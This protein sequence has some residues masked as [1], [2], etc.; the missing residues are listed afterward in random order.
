MKNEQKLQADVVVVGTGGSGMA[1]ATS[2]LEAGANKIIVLEKS[3][4]LGGNTWLAGGLCAVDSP[5]Q[6]RLGITGTSDKLFKQ[7]MEYSHWRNDP[8]I[9][10]T[11]LDKSSE[12]IQWLEDKGL[13]FKYVGAAYADSV[14]VGH[15]LDLGEKGKCGRPIIKT[16]AKQLRSHGVKILLESKAEKILL[17]NKGNVRGVL[18]NIKGKETEV[19]TK[20]LILATGGFGWNKK[21]LKKYFPGYNDSVFS[22]GLPQMTGDGLLMAQ[23]AGAQLNEDIVFVL[24]GPHHYPYSRRITLLQRR[25]EV[26]W[27]NKLGERF[28]DESTFFNVAA[29]ASLALSQ[30]PGAISYTIIDSKNLQRILD[31]KEPLTGFEAV[32]GDNGA[33]LTELKSN[34][35]SEAKGWATVSQL[36]AD[37][38]NGCGICEDACSWHVIK[39]NT[40]PEGQSEVSPCR[41][42]C[43]AGVNMR[44]YIHLLRYGKMEEAYAVLRESLP[45]P[46]VTG[47]VCPHFCES[48]CARKDVDEAVNINSLERFVADYWSQEKAKPVAKKYTSK[49]AVVGSGP[50]GL[51]CAYFLAMAGYPV[52]VFESQSTLGGMLRTGIPEYRLP[53]KILDE[54]INYIRDIGVEFKTGV[55]IGKE[56]S[57]KK[58]QQEYQAVFL[59]TGN[60]LSRKIELEGSGLNGVQ[61]GLD[62]LQVVNLNKASNVKGKVVVIGGGNVA[63]D[64]ALT[65]IR[66]GAKDVQLACL[67]SGSEIPAYKEELEQAVAEGVKINEGWGPQR[68]LGDKGKVT[69]IELVRCTRVFDAQGKF[70]P[71]YDKKTIKNLDADMVI[72]AIGQTPDHSLTPKDIKINDNGS[73][74]T[75]PITLETNIGGV[76]AGGDIVAGAG[77]VVKAIADGK[78]A[79]ISID[80]YVK[81]K[82]LKKGRTS[83]PEKMKNPPHDG[84]PQ[85]DRISTTLLNLKDRVGNFK[86]VKVGFDENAAIQESER[87]T[88]CGSK[89]S[90]NIDDCHGCDWCA[91]TCP[92]KAI[93]LS[94]ARKID[95]LV[96]I[97]DNLDDIA[98]WIGVESAVLKATVDRYNS[99]CEKG[100]DDDFSKDNKFLFPI[101][102]PPYYAIYARNGFDTSLGGIKINYRMEVLDKNS[103]PIGGLYAIGN[104]AGGWESECYNFYL[105]GG[106]LGFA[107]TGGYLA[108]ENAAKYVRS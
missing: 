91:T 17:D 43:P 103:K 97:A 75:D 89:S 71:S 35:E 33:W 44:K 101:S 5:V 69:G 51:S 20:S 25:P 7:H 74:Q 85:M 26:L 60:Q 88:T 96:K 94:P 10:R 27:V 29:M 81:G 87:C 36:K 63:V 100:H 98:K 47:R 21:L 90:L 66:L 53:K 31:S 58:L 107:I 8:K 61:W 86:E 76:F 45:L 23:A 32:L 105:I 79:M 57:F 82:D 50:A 3:D 52:T 59:A 83:K 68:I 1:A 18:A 19:E 42:A 24:F 102:T 78:T 64:V 95:P 73:I 13:K 99:F 16:L 41:F 80:R 106:S 14:P 15:M 72:L 28:A 54:Q 65:A 34:L 70:S 4:K 92:T 46:A 56:V 39:L 9:V 22:Q 108:G 11:C 38:C 93:Y 67:E 48:E 2:A 55:T 84:I 12:I 30:Q 40:S 6:K 104:T 49:I 62:F 77:S 37:L